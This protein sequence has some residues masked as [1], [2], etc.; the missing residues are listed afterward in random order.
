MLISGNVYSNCTLNTQIILNCM[1][2]KS[3]QDKG[4]QLSVNAY[5]NLETRKITWITNNHAITWLVIDIE[6][7]IRN[8]IIIC[9]QVQT[10]QQY[11]K[12][13]NRITMLS[14]ENLISSSLKSKN[15]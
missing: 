1:F 14:I 15:K 2:T 5:N 6:I 13:N 9:A 10:W 4:L 11:L 12:S 3:F 8:N 7:I